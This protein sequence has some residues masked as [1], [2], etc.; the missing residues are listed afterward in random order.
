MSLQAPPVDRRAQPVRQ[1]HQHHQLVRGPVPVLEQVS[2]L[3]QQVDDSHAPLSAVLRL[4]PPRRGHDVLAR[5]R[6]AVRELVEGGVVCQHAVL[7]PMADLGR[8]SI[9]LKNITKN[10]TKIITK[11]LHIKKLQ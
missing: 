2:H 3:R 7:D 1:H 5:Q 11:K 9:A 6:S 8:D 4:G 10:I